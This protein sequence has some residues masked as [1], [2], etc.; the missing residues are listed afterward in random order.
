MPSDLFAG[1][2]L[3]KLGD[4]VDDHQLARR[5]PAGACTSARPSKAQR[6][7]DPRNL[8]GTVQNDILKEYQ[9]RSGTYIYP[10]AAGSMRL[11]V[12]RRRLLRGGDVPEVAS[13]FRSPATTCAK[14]DAPLYKKWL[15]P[16]LT[17]SRM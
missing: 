4:D 9:A 8:G 16:W 5:D 15:S 6:G 2:D 14:R 7:R 13:R 3:E 1:I 17:A 10:A 12:G 11:V